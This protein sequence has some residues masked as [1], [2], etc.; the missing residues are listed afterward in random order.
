MTSKEFFGIVTR[1][2]FTPIIIAVYS[3]VI[4]LLLLGET[5]DAYF[6]NGAYSI[7]YL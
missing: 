5:R 4:G 7:M 3:L 6:V 1:N 2:F